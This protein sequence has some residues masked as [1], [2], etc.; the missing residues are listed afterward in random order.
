M[1][2]V[3]ETSIPE[4]ELHP[5]AESIMHNLPIGDVSS[6]AQIAVYTDGSLPKISNSDTSEATSAWAFTTCGLGGDGGFYRRGHSS[7]RLCNS[8]ILANLA[9]TISSTMP[10]LIA[11]LYATI[12]ISVAKPIAPVTIY[13][14][15]TTM[16]VKGLLPLQA[17]VLY[18]TLL[19]SCS[20]QHTVV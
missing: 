17:S 2:F 16:L 1:Q 4:V 14:E 15:P 3:L 7:Q 13:S 10:E 6:A 19:F 11:I 18:S 20:V 9:P 12:W 5:F 8:G